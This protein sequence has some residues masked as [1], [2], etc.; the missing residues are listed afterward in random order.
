LRTQVT[1]ELNDDF[2]KEIGGGQTVAEMREKVKGDL[3]AAERAKLRQQ[4]R[5][6]V[7]AQ[8]LKR[9]PFEI[10][11]AMVENATDNM[12]QSALRSMARSGLD[13][14]QLRM[15]FHALRGEMKDKAALEVKGRLALEAICRKENIDVSEADVEAKIQ[16][17][18]KE[19]SNTVETIRN[20]L[21]DPSVKRQFYEKLLEE[22]T[23]EFLKARA[24]YS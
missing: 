12:L 16:E 6:E 4:E 2:A 14:S 19:T 3:L 8:V 23:I 21:E 7:I 5:D 18:A 13:P 24:K 9:N 11:D 10:P 20:A 22:K 1:P 17:L 15:D